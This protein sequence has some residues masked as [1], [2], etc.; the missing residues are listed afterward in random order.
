MPMPRPAPPSPPGDD[1]RIQ[2]L[3]LRQHL[4]YVSQSLTFSPKDMPKPLYI[5]VSELNQ[6]VV[7]SDQ[8]DLC[9][10]IDNLLNL[11]NDKSIDY[12][13]QELD[14]YDPFGNPESIIISHILLD[15]LHYEHWNQYYYK[16]MSDEDLLNLINLGIKKYKV[17]KKKKDLENDF[18]GI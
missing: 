16:N 7:K 2:L 17:E 9:V 1:I 10:R 5:R 4:N 18:Q 12:Y 11:T 15:I 14:C 8:I 13:T 3:Y 6:R